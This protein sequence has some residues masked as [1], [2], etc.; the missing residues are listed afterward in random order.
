MRKVTRNIVS[1]FIA[2]TQ[3]NEGNS[4]VTIEQDGSVGKVTFLR[5]FGNKIARKLTGNKNC[6]EISNAG[7]FSNTTKERLN[8]LPNVSIGQIRGVWYLNGNV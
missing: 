3:S 6:F 5:L 4:S 1:C 8:A 2:D 7:W